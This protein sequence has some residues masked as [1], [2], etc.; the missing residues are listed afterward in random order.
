MSAWKVIVRALLGSGLCILLAALIWPVE[1][2]NP[3]PHSDLPAPQAVRNI[4]RRSCSDCHSNETRWPWYA[5]IPPASWLVVRD[6]TIGRKEMNFSNWTLYSTAVRTRKARW[7]NR[8]LQQENM[9]PWEYRLV[10]PDARVTEAE[11]IELERWLRLQM[12]NAP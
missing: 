1:L 5:A 10:H 4:L 2:T 7:M 8:S 9:P 6:V 11:R 12:G 3:Q